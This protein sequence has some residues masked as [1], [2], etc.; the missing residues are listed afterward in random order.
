MPDSAT[1]SKC[2]HCE[3]ALAANAARCTSCGKW[4]GSSDVTAHDDLGT[5]ASTNW[6]RAM[7]PPAESSGGSG[8]ALEVGSILA[9]RYEILKLLGEGGMG[10]VY[11]AHDKELDR[12][13]AL[14]VIR[15][16]L[17]GHP[18]VLARF[19]QELLLARKITHRNV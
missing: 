14:K 12:L 1:S 7:R 5:N 3:Q 2:P 11:K 18:T 9:E 13:V 16:E 10:A 19:K 8:L 17:A 4:V 6:S 15:S